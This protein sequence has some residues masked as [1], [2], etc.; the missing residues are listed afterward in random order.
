MLPRHVRR[1]SLAGEDRQ[2]RAERIEPGVQLQAARVRL[3]H[4]VR[5]RIV[6]RLED[7]RPTCRSDSA[8]HGSYADGYIASLAIRTCRT[9]AFN[10]IAAA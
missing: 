1:R 3:L 4:G 6:R 2:H 5:Q 7:L 8:D 9:I 10:P